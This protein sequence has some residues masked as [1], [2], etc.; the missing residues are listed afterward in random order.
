MPRRDAMSLARVGEESRTWL[1]I[2]AEARADV[3][4]L[5]LEDGCDAAGFSDFAKS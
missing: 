1:P 2:R 5:G 4:D 3:G